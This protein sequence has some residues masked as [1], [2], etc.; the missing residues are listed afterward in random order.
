M[1]R[2]NRQAAAQAIELLDVRANDKVLEVGSG[3][4]VGV[5]LLLE[6]VIGGWVA[7]VDQ[8]QEMV[9]QAA[10]RNAA[11]LR[12]RTVDLRYGSVE[13]LPFTEDAFD[14]ALAINSMQVHPMPVSAA[15]DT[16]VLEP[17]DTVALCFTANSGQSKDGITEVSR[18]G[19]ICTRANSGPGKAVLR[20]RHKAMKPVSPPSR[21]FTRR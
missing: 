10:A 21:T 11:A 6:C 5:Q 4:G 15:G 8:S 9:G 17:S 2:V 19:R 14:K 12:E 16:G 1:A 3:P 20:D 7:G 18:Q 13:R